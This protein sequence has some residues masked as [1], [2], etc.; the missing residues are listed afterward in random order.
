VP[1][2]PTCS[3]IALMLTVIVTIAGALR[4]PKWSRAR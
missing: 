1:P 2:A 4:A 3:V